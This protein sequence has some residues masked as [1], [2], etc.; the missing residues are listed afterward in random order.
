LREAF[1][2]RRPEAS[3]LK[4]EMLMQKTYAWL[5]SIDLTISAVILAFIFLDILL[6]VYSR[7]APGTAPRWT[8]EMGSILLCALIWM[9]IGSGIESNAHIRFDMIIGLFPPKIRKTFDIIGNIIFVIFLILLSVYTMQMLL[10]YMRMG[11]STVLL[12]WNKGWTKMPM[13]LGL[14]IASLRLVRI[15]IGSFAAFNEDAKSRHDAIK[16]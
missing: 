9:G 12:Q 3:V 1:R 6:Q 8:V 10:W 13:F 14:A 7:V 11:T 5:K 2:G 15:I 4:L 16:R